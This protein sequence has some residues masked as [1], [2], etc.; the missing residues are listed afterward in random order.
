LANNKET[1]DLVD[2]V[3]TCEKKTLKGERFTSVEL[4]KLAAKRNNEDF[5]DGVDII[6]KTYKPVRSVWFVEASI[7][8]ETKQNTN[9]IVN[10]F[11]R[12]FKGYSLT[13]TKLPEDA[14][15][16]T[17]VLLKSC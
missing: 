12:F 6:S 11:S 8:D 15:S 4:Q 3:L 2:M 17:T 1:T 14:M 16:S 5:S 13:I 7:I 9:T 10:V